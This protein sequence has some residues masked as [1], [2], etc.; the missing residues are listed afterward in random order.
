VHM[1]TYKGHLDALQKLVE[2]GAKIDAESTSHGLLP[3]HTA[4]GDELA[5]FER[6]L[7]LGARFDAVNSNLEQAIHHAARHDNVEVHPLSFSPF[8]PSFPFFL[9]YGLI[10]H[11]GPSKIARSGRESG[12]CDKIRK[13][14]GPLRR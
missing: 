7:A 3:I 8:S 6:V 5:V 13:A 11:S 1:A 12:R 14:P 10:F 9:L 4:A 2:L